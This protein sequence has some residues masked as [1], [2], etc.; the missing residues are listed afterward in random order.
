MA[1]GKAGV[2]IGAGGYDG[3][4]GVGG[5]QE[6]DKTGLGM[7]LYDTGCEGT[8]EGRPLSTGVCPPASA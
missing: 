8:T 7:V 5:E 2:G 1:R 3:G 6:Q 4:D